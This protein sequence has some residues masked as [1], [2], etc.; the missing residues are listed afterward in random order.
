MN[1]KTVF[2]AGLFISVTIIA[3]SAFAQH[4]DNRTGRNFKVTPAVDAHRQA[5]TSPGPRFYDTTPATPN[6]FEAKRLAQASVPASPLK[7]GH[8]MSLNFRK[9]DIR[10]LISVLAIKHEINIVMS[11]EVTG[12]VSV[13]LY[14]VTLDEAL[15]AITLAGGFAFKKY[16]DLYYVFKPPK[17]K[18]PGSEKLKMWVYKLK[19]GQIDKVQEIMEAFPEINFIKI[20]EPSKTVIVQD[21]PENIEKI[22]AILSYLDA[23]PKQV[24]IEA[25]I[26]EV[27]LTDDMSLGVNW[28]KILGDVRIGTGGLSTAT[29]PTA[30]ADSVSPVPTTGSGV[31]GNIITA[32][33]TRHQFAAAVDALQSKTKVDTLSTPKIL[34]IHGKTARVQV[35][36]QQGYRVTT[37]NQ[38]IATESIEFI[39]TGTILEITPYINEEG[40]VLLNVKPSIKSAEIQQG[41][42]VV[43]TTDVST[44]LLAQ[45]GET[46]FIGGL[47]QDTKTHTRNMIPCLGGIP[48]LGLVFGRSVHGI[49]KSEL[50][51]LITSQIVGDESKQ[52]DQKEME[53]I[54][55]KE[56]QFKKG[57]EHPHKDLMNGSPFKGN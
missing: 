36:G 45:D 5:L 21:T 38:G 24:I 34:A 20:H 3:G 29:I 49:G 47:I 18:E 11:K 16:N 27:T 17:A 6:A 23:T 57:F 50:V 52:T 33:G 22:E 13:H 40:S 43:K 26:L 28:E 48:G 54:L 35:G 42:P 8:L 31:F 56:E 32:A 39:D 15:D 12:K 53:K 30:A 55:E 51:V 37:V 19:Y 9:I 1:I 14:Q 10:E 25:K 4:M 46:V 2:L 41:I 7:D 44:W